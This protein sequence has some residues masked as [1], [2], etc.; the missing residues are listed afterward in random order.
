MQSRM[1]LEHF[2][3][4]KDRSIKFENKLKFLDIN[5]NGSLAVIQIVPSDTRVNL[6]DSDFWAKEEEKYAMRRSKA[7]LCYQ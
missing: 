7:Y 5:S 4:L 2:G 1:T 3:I 6:T